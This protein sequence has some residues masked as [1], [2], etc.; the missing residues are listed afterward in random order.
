MTDTENFIRILLCTKNKVGARA[1]C[2]L[3]LM[4]GKNEH[5]DVGK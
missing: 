3:S 2:V 1:H 4:S 5:I